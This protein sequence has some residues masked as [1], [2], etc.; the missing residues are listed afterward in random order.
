MADGFCIEGWNF[1]LKDGN[2]LVRVSEHGSGSRCLRI[3]FVHSRRH[4]SSH[5]RFFSAKKGGKSK[6]NGR[7]G[8]FV[9]PIPLVFC[10]GW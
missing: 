4:G 2:Q 10:V 5:I 9:E 1:A 6:Q 3:V 8:V 7:F